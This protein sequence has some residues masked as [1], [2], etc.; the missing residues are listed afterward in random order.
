ML[1]KWRVRIYQQTCSDLPAWNF[2]KITTK[3]RIEVNK[4]LHRIKAHKILHKNILVK[5]SH[6]MSSWSCIDCNTTEFSHF[7]HQNCNA[8]KHKIWVTETDR[9]VSI[10]MGNVYSLNSSNLRLLCSHFTKIQDFE[11]ENNC[12]F[13]FTSIELNLNI[14]MKCL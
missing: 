14:K 8:F 4:C 7:F 9:K 2:N 13:G 3:L 10:L 12:L 6:F 11:V 1:L 5:V